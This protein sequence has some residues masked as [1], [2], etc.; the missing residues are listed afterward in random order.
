MRQCA[1]YIV[2]V[3]AI[4]SAG[5]VG[6]RLHTATIYGGTITTSHITSFHRGDN[7]LP[8]DPGPEL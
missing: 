1:E 2:P 7:S 3:D 4:D 5:M 6:W 8:C